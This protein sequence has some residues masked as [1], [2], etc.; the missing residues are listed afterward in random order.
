MIYFKYDGKH[1]FHYG[2][3]NMWE[4]KLAHRFTD[5]PVLFDEVAKDIEEWGGIYRAEGLEIVFD[6]DHGAMMFKLKYGTQNTI[7][8]W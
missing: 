1:Y 8:D 3:Y 6:N 2:V 7:D 5:E 4:E